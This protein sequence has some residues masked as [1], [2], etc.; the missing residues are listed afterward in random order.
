MA[1]P[2]RAPGCST[3]RWH[4]VRLILTGVLLGALITGRL[5]TASMFAS[6]RL[7][8]VS[9]LPARPASLPD[10]STPTVK[11]KLFSEIALQQNTAQQHRQAQQQHQA[12]LRDALRTSPSLDSQR[13]ETRSLQ[14]H[15]NY[16]LA[17]VMPFIDA[18]LAKLFKCFEH[19]L[20]A[21]PCDASLP[22]ALLLYHPTSATD[23]NVSLA[24]VRG[25][26]RDSAGC[27]SLGIELLWANL[28]A[29]VAWSHPDGT[30][31][32][33]YM[34][35]GLLRSRFDYFYLMEPDAIAIRP[36]WLTFLVAEVQVAP[37]TSFW[38]KGSVSRCSSEYGDMRRQ[39]NLHI[40]GG[41]L[42]CVP[43]Q[44]DNTGL[45]AFLGAVQR[46]FP[47]GFE[48]GVDYGGCAM[49][50]F[51]H[52][53]Y[54]F[55]HSAINFDYVRPILHLYQYT[56]VLHN[57]CEE[58][59][60]PVKVL[61]ENPKAV[62]VH[63]KGPFF[64]DLDLYIREEFW[65][66]L[67]RYPVK[68]TEQAVW[69]ERIRNGS[70]SKQQIEQELCVSE[71]YE[72]RLRRGHPS[73]ACTR[74]C[75]AG[76]NDRKAVHGRQALTSVGYR[77]CKPAFER[78]AWQ[79]SLPPAV[80]YV[81]TVDFHS[82]PMACSE[83]LLVELGA[84][85][86]SE[87]DFGNCVYH[88]HMCKER[89]KVLAYDNWAGFSLDPCPNTMRRAFFEAYKHDEELSRVDLFVCSHPAANCELFMPF[90]RPMLVYATTRIEFG[91]YDETVAW[92]QPYLDIHGGLKYAAHRWSQWVANLQR[93]ASKPGNVIAANN[94]F[95]VHAIKY[96]TNITP[97]YLPSWCG[98]TGAN[99]VDISYS[100]IKSKPVLLGPYRDN[101]GN[102]TLVDGLD[103]Q[104]WAHPIFANL[105][106]ELHRLPATPLRIRRMR[107]E[108][109]EYEWEQVAE[110]PAI[111]Y[112]PYQ[113]STISFFEL[114]RANIPIF[115]PSCELLTRWTLEHGIMWERVYGT[116]PRLVHSDEPDA[117]HTNESLHY[118]LSKSDFYLFP[119][120]QLF[121]SWAE[122]L[123]ML[124]SVDLRRVSRQMVAANARQRADIKVQWAAILES[125]V[126]QSGRPFA[127]A[128]GFDDA[129]TALWG[130]QEPLHADP[131]RKQCS[132]TTLPEPPQQLAAVE[133]HRRPFLLPG[134]YLGGGMLLNT[135][136][137]LALYVHSQHELCSAPMELSLARRTPAPFHL[138]L[139]DTYP[140]I[141]HMC[142]HQGLTPVT[143]RLSISRRDR[144]IW[145]KWMCTGCIMHLSDAGDLYWTNR[146]GYRKLLLWGRNN[147]LG[148]RCWSPPGIEPGTSASST[149]VMQEGAQ[150]RGSQESAQGVGSQESS[151]LVHLPLLLAAAVLVGVALLPLLRRI[152]HCCAS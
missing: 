59:Y 16:S 95:D 122:C 6:Q 9:A 116:P 110:H 75:M 118:W 84:R 13:L 57:L 66:I 40:N 62:I 56:D 80:P 77:C 126:A 120:V 135:R 102:G 74:R 15:R 115:I 117:P 91:R 8:E 111:I 14:T 32:Q 130:E 151:R 140:R 89:L 73:E 20:V 99:G 44:S 133:A 81:W 121:N 51:D 52:S 2:N 97:V 100:P 34:L 30:C 10:A 42:Y 82:G 152:R 92:R 143:A 53:I 33:F 58:D 35:F 106:A 93:I 4:K 60:S 86:H 148:G 68:S 63:S 29:A 147:S 78:L 88:P 64:S 103:V 101:I 12:E 125:A 46:F 138:R 123:Q 132:V 109:D 21:P 50:G 41:A 22:A 7:T 24:E 72:A 71:A 144:P 149:A 139:H 127:P 19:W 146:S 69:H 48:L 98:L 1:K 85:V 137:T 141:G 83:P 67:G 129:M 70:A 45:T 49:G 17:V 134:D 3:A 18:Q 37:C 142:M 150:G 36:N 31:G 136:N 54:W 131:S 96:H 94:M 108:Y 87:I 112:I 28:S 124:R 39:H 90:D 25:K 43:P 55:L 114:Y 119:H 105:T 61:A 11:R 26:L 113:V 104:A 76:S 38:I 107:E 128:D 5:Q 79:R 145:C 65:R 23:S 47:S 27:F